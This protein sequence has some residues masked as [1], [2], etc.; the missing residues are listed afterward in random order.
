MNNV[1]HPVADDDIDPVAVERCVA[2]TLTGHPRTIAEREAAVVALYRRGYVNAEICRR[3]GIALAHIKPV[4]ARHGMVPVKRYQ[5]V[6]RAPG[7]CTPAQASRVRALIATRST[8][9]DEAREL[10]LVLGL[11]EAVPVWSTTA[12][13]AAA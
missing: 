8:N 7:D 2:G 5:Y 4:L 6:R 9:L 1:L 3:T 13:E 12:G 11:V 10:L